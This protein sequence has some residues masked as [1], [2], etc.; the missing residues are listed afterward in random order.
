MLILPKPA[1]RPVAKLVS[2]YGLEGK[3]VLNLKIF[4]NLK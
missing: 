2:I 1:W 4:V 3:A